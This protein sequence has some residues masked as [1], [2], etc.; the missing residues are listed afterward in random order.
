MSLVLDER[1]TALSGWVKVQL[2]RE[3]LILAPASAD[4]SFRRYFRV[5]I[6]DE[7]YIV[8]D[9]PPG[10]EDLRPYIHAVRQFLALGLHV[11]QILAQDL[12]QGFLLLSDLGDR[13]YLSELSET[14]VERLY[15]DA[16]AALV[17]LQT[18]TD[19]GPD[20][21]PPYDRN[22][23]RAEMDLFRQWYVPLQLKVELTGR[24]SRILEQAFELLE[25][26]A[27]AQPQVWVHRD[28]HSRNLMLTATNNPGILDF[29]DAVCGP[30]TYDLVS[31]L[32]DCY[33]EWPAG[34]VDEWALGYHRLARQSGVPIPDDEQQFLDWFDLTGI[35][36]H[37]KVLGIFTRLYHRD[38]KAA[39]L[40]DIPRVLTY[41]LA[42][43]ARQRDLA[44]LHGLLR[45]LHPEGG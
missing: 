13:T 43:T 20:R 9:A 38:G 29:Q 24:Q 44:E 7:S 40:Q 42:A 23:L 33:I 19:L 31:L 18:G 16:L 15:G 34:R 41:L 39:Y 6:R 17:V 35:Q 21:F 26:A 4:A 10:R 8:M 2:G 3:D 14:T 37:I 11:P 27:L 45:A 28:Y 5:S 25:N 1:L 22:L 32:R 36:R 30:V 12:T